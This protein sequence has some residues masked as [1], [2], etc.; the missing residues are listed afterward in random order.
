MS[1]QTEPIMLSS[2]TEMEVAI[3]GGSWI[4]TLGTAGGV[5]LLIILLVLV[6]LL[7]V[8]LVVGVCWW[9][10][11]SQKK[12]INKKFECTAVEYQPSADDV[13]DHYSYTKLTSVPEDNLPVNLNMKTFQPSSPYNKQ[14]NTF[15]PNGSTNEVNTSNSFTNNTNNPNF[16]NSSTNQVNITPN[17]P[18]SYNSNPLYKPNNSV[19]TA[20]NSLTNLTNDMTNLAYNYP[21]NQ[22]IPN[23]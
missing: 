4:W 22:G 19:D 3:S 11:R 21:E 15:S 20:F 5:P 16:I 10:K 14:V 13:E 1:S 2:S 23:K 7:V 12:E 18:I 8:V 17:S 6:V 9:H